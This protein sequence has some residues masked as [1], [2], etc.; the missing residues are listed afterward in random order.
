MSRVL[1]NALAVTTAALAMVV[2]FSLASAPALAQAGCGL[3]MS[4]QC[5]SF[6]DFEVTG[7]DPID[8]DITAGHFS[9]DFAITRFPA[10]NLAVEDVT[11]GGSGVALATVGSICTVD[12]DTAG[13]V[14]VSAVLNNATCQKAGQA[15]GTE[16]DPTIP[17]D[18]VLPCIA[19]E[20]GETGT[21][22]AIG[23]LGGASGLTCPDVLADPG[24]GAIVFRH[25]SVAACVVPDP[26]EDLV[27]GDANVDIRDRAEVQ[28]TCLNS[29][30]V[31]TENATASAEDSAACAP[32]TCPNVSIVKSCV[33][34]QFPSCEADVEITVTNSGDGPATGCVVTDTL[35]GNPLDLTGTPCE[36]PFDLAEAGAAGDEVICAINDIPLAATALNEVAVDCD[37]DAPAGL[38][39]QTEDTNTATCECVNFQPPT[40]DKE[41]D[42]CVPGTPNTNTFRISIMNPNDV[43]LECTVEDDFGGVPGTGFPMDVTVPANDTLVVEGTEDHAGDAV[44]VNEASVTC[45]APNGQ[46]FGPLTAMANC[47]PCEA[48]EGCYTRTPG[49]WCARPLAT[50]HLLELEV[51]GITLD[52]VNDAEQGSAIEDLRVGRDHTI[53]DSRGRSVGIDPA[54][55]GFPNGIEPQN[56]QL[57]R[58]CTAATLNLAATEAAEGN[59][60]TE[61][62]GI[63]QTVA[64]C[65]SHALCTA[66]ADAISA[67]GCIADLDEFNNMDF[68]GI[69]FGTPDG[70]PTS[71]GTGVPGNFPP[72]PADSSTCSEVNGNGFINDRTP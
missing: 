35:G 23:G 42:E 49:F 37:D 26:C 39:C 7:G 18:C 69:D 5:D 28:G 54:T 11:P 55:L 19:C 58:Q 62:P 16:C 15:A 63:V 68:G 34:E 24:R 33:T 17:G 67:S 64:D 53:D 61:S 14:F 12:S 27:I 10:G 45:D 48:G 20:A 40:V 71:N 3:S 44:I 32:E 6:V 21:D 70:F 25:E 72:G 43:D 51:C 47:P 4:K 60:D 9:S 56:L 50:E 52:N 66:P 46:M 31:N 29:G 41:C 2:G 13:E 57:I 22:D 36:A 65:C 59:C 38:V 30:E 8:C 1:G